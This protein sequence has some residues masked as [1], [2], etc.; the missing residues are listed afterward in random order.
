MKMACLSFFPPLWYTSLEASHLPQRVGGGG[1]VGVRPGVLVD[2]IAEG[3]VL[4]GP[5][6]HVSPIPLDA[7]YFRNYMAQ[8]ST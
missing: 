4:H 5:H 2:A 1:G 3:V 8:V 6:S 7:R